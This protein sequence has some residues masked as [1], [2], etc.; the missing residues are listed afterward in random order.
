VWGAAMVYFAR[1]VV[2]LTALNWVSSRKFDHFVPIAGSLGAFL[3]IDR[4]LPYLPS[5]LWARLPLALVVGLIFSV[6]SWYVL[7][8]PLQ[9]RLRLRLRSGGG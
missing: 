9:D 4:A 8:R 7:P 1:F 5:G 2:D 6:Q 3:L